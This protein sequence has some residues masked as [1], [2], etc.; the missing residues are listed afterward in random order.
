M[1]YPTVES[2]SS[3]A[4]YAKNIHMFSDSYLEAANTSYRTYS[5]ALTGQ[6]GDAVQ[7]FVDK[8]NT[9]QSQVFDQY[10]TALATYAQT[11]ATYEEALTGHGFNERMWSDKSGSEKLKELYTGDQATEISDKVTE[12]N[13]LLKSAAEAAGVEAPDLSSIKTTATEGFKKAGNDRGDLASDIDSKWKT[14][15]ETLTNNAETIKAFQ[16]AI[17]N[18][19]YLSQLSL[20]DIANKIVNGQLSAEHMYYLNGVQNVHDAEAINILL[21][22]ANYRSDEDFFSVLG[23]I[24]YADKL[25]E[26]AADVIHGRLYEEIDSLYNNGLSHS[27]NLGY[28]FQ[29]MTTRLTKEQAEAYS[30]KMSEASARFA[31]LLK[32]QGIA[33]VPDFG[34]SIEQHE[35]HFQGM[36]E[37]APLFRNIDQELTKASLLGNV[38]DYIYSYNLG[39]NFNTKMIEPQNPSTRYFQEISYNVMSG[40]GIDA[41]SL[42]FNFT[43]GTVDFVVSKGYI[44]EAFPFTQYYSDPWGAKPGYPREQTKVHIDKFTTQNQGDMREV[45]Q[46]IR[47]LQKDKDKAEKDMYANIAVSA[48]G[49]IPYVAPVI[50]VMKK[51]LYDKEEVNLG[52]AGDK[53]PVFKTVKGIYD[54]VVKYKEKLKSID[55]DISRQQ[56]KFYDKLFDTSGV[57]VDQGSGKEKVYSNRTYDLQ[58]ALMQYDLQENGLQSYIYTYERSDFATHKSKSPKEAGKI[59]SDFKEFYFG[60]SDAMKLLRGEGGIVIDDHSKSINGDGKISAQDTFNEFDRLMTGNK[61]CD[62]TYDDFKNWQDFYGAY[63]RDLVNNS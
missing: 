9:L 15:T 21:N 47:K 17:N 61:V 4:S 37:T 32:L 48:T 14:F 63:Y 40:S 24:N 41:H 27:D 11:V 46:R 12:M 51:A 26:G 20:T 23:S 57:S 53:I 38:F 2:I 30:K 39:F 49:E 1:V 6:H 34:D 29:A 58:S 8:L 28:Y 18:A 10:P 50:E 19:T 25:S 5:V 31:G 22:E 43:N 52:D 44:K 62:Q 13:N 55:S 33:A 59:V 45:N 7:A 60:D 42:N 36:K 56:S 35:K 16:P 3:L 54:N